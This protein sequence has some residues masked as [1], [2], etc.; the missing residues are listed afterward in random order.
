[1][2]LLGSGLFYGCSALE[3]VVLPDVVV[4]IGANAFN[5]CTSIGKLVIPSTVAEVLA[6][7]FSG[8]TAEQ[9]LAVEISGQEAALWWND[10]WS[11]GCNAA[12]SYNYTG[13]ESSAY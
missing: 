1:M 3:T 5:G 2:P 12:I 4:Q 7:A 11:E 9:Q 10:S 8:W 13:E 6:N